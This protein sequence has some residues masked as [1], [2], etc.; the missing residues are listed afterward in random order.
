MKKLVLTLLIAAA[1]LPALAA[2]KLDAL[3]PE[4]ARHSMREVLQTLVRHALNFRKETPLTAE[5]RGQVKAVL[6]AHRAEARSIFTRGREAR[7]ALVEAAKK[8]GADAPATREA[9]EKNG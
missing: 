3:V 4:A 1:A 7:H 9:A 2:P 8:E 5:Q 6:A